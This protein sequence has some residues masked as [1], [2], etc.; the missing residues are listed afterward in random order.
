MKKSGRGMEIL[1]FRHFSF[2]VSLTCIEVLFLIFSCASTISSCVCLRDLKKKRRRRPFSA[3]S[4]RTNSKELY[5]IHIFLSVS[6]I[7]PVKSTIKC[8]FH[9]FHLFF[10]AQPQRIVR[11]GCPNLSKNYTPNRSVPHESRYHR[12][13]TGR[14][15]LSLQ[16]DTSDVTAAVPAERRDRRRGENSLIAHFGR[17]N[18]M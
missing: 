7:F 17:Q 4:G 16:V 1:Q 15:E 6:L 14:T 5:F 2:S 13:R 9:S 8:I 12:P 3:P 18:A 11:L 10:G